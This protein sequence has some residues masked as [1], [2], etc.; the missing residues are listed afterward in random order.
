MSVALSSRA[1]PRRTV[2]LLCLLALIASLGLSA[3]PVA[4]AAT[5]VEIQPHAYRPAA[6]PVV[7]SLRAGADLFDASSI[8]W[9][10]WTEYDEDE[11]QALDRNE[12]LDLLPTSARTAD[13]TIPTLQEERDYR[14]VVEARGAEHEAFLTA[15]AP[16]QWG[17][18]SYLSFD[19]A[20]IPGSEEA[21]L[22][23][24]SYEA[25]L[26]EQV[27]ELEVT[28]TSYDDETGEEEQRPVSGATVQISS[29]WQ[30]ELVLPAGALR[31]GD[32]VSVSFTS[33][34]SGDV[35]AYGWAYLLEPWIE[36]ATSHLLVG[37]EPDSTALTFRAH[38]LTF[39]GEENLTVSR[40]G[41]EPLDVLGDP[42][43]RVL[44][45]AAG[46]LHRVPAARLVR[47]HA[48]RERVRLRV[49]GA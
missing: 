41:E 40:W 22:P 28:V 30:G 31:R 43:A 26:T 44:D 4:N 20:F 16:S 12:P 36:M 25:W 14:I 7:A 47:G 5:W 46:S 19:E 49:L 29:A 23:F 15:V 21:R 27:E 2:S 39:T 33:G 17:S 6:P 32:E 45:R 1:L 11:E 24:R 8:A 9:L 3:P 18:E 38:G 48:R 13:V 42:R 10:S 35:R 34:E 37:F